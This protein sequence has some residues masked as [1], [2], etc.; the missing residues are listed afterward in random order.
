[1]NNNRLIVI[2]IAVVILVAG[3]VVV[4]VRTG[5][6]VAPVPPSEPPAEVAETPKNTPAAS[7]PPVI[8]ATP[9]A[10]SVSQAQVPEVALPADDGPAY[11]LYEEPFLDMGDIRRLIEEHG[12][13][14][15]YGMANP[16]HRFDMVD[17]LTDLE[18]LRENLETLLGTETDSELRAYMLENT[19]PIGLFDDAEIG[20]E[21]VDRELVRILREAPDEGVIGVEWVRRMDLARLVDPKEALHWARQSDE[22][23]PGDHEIGVVA[24]ETI[25]A[26]HG[27][28]GG[29]R[30]SEVEQA[31]SFIMETLATDDLAVI[32]SDYR[33]RAYVSLANAT[34]PDQV[35]DFYAEQ[36]ERESD[37]RVRR[38]LERLLSAP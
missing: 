13:E 24:S 3:M 6:K 15:A 22:R 28:D 35:R 2:G 8:E 29:V 7:P 11:D 21:V 4:M 33:L 32:D 16:D 1:M 9:E 23:Y 25:L 20:E 34:D 17:Y 38:M 14:K 26:V 12:L 10:I 31:Q 36:L 27:S 19:V 30:V 18:L 37:P 5:D